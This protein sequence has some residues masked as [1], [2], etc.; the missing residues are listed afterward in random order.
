MDLHWDTN[1]I[2]L[3]QAY[4]YTVNFEANES[5]IIYESPFSNQAG[6]SSQTPNNLISDNAYWEVVTNLSNP[7]NVVRLQAPFSSDY[8]GQYP[9]FY[10]PY[11]NTLW[12]GDAT[13]S[14]S[15]TM[16]IPTN[17]PMSKVQY[18]IAI[19]NYYWLYVNGTYVGTG[20]DNGLAAWSSFQS[21]PTNVLH[22]G[23]NNINMQ[24]Q[25]TGPPNYFSMVVTTNNCD[26]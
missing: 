15:I 17:T 19:D 26:Y 18:S 24:I 3:G 1:N 14:N 6:G 7:T 23:T 5:F 13:W 21:F 20:Q 2:V 16:V 12:P 4:Y 22:Y 9:G 25:D 11:P 10:Y 8:P